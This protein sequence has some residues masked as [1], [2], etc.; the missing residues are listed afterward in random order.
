MILAVFAWDMKGDK[1]ERRATRR[2]TDRFQEKQWLQYEKILQER[3]RELQE[4]I[5]GKKP[6]DR[7]RIIQDELMKTA[8]EVAGENINR[9]EGAGGSEVDG[10]NHREELELNKEEGLRERKRHPSF[11][12]S[13]HIYHAR[14]YT[15]GNG[16][17]GGFWK[18]KEIRNDYIM[19]QI[20]R[21][22]RKA[23][24]AR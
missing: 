7:L 15:G 11:L 4:K 17:V 3:T 2:Y 21:V 23:R 5:G 20:T 19:K 24:R 16:K 10:H 8:A 14:R 9:A 1:G 6:S 12:W 18:R 22:D 13:R